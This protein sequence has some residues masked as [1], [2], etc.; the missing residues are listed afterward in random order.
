MHLTVK[1][2]QKARVGVQI[3]VPGRNSVPPVREEKQ[4]RTD[5][6]WVGSPPPMGEDDDEREG[7]EAREAERAGEVMR[8]SRENRAKVPRTRAGRS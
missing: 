7:Q 3:M 8:F 1:T 5:R 4:E 2:A 6:K